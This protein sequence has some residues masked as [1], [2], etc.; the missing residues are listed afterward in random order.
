MK[1][2]KRLT[3]TSVLFFLLMSCAAQAQSDSQ[4]SANA[5][6]NVVA[7]A[8]KG[9]YRLITP[10]EL[11]DEYLRDPA[12]F[13]LVD[14]RQEWAYQMQHIGGALHIDF[15][16]TWWNQYSP[17]TRSEMKK[18]LGPEKNRKIVFY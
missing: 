4:N 5:W 3:Y 8:E 15:A 17:M 14:V 7:E 11:R 13:I 18:V 2:I 16:P 9:G 1:A 10:D 6:E 12:S